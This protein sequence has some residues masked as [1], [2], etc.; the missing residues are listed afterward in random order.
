MQTTG[1]FQFENSNLGKFAVKV[2]GQDCRGYTMADMARRDRLQSK[3]TDDDYH[4][5]NAEYNARVQW[6]LKQGPAFW[7]ASD[8]KH[9]APGDD[10]KFVFGIPPWHPDGTPNPLGIPDNRVVEAVPKGFELPVDYDSKIGWNCTKCYEWIPRL[11]REYVGGPEPDDWW[12]CLSCRKNRPKM[13]AQAKKIEAIN[14]QIKDI[15][16]LLE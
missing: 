6:C 12:W 7:P 14:R 3:L 4:R 5:H 8:N 16:S 9:R 10:T 11:P 13:T 1:S 2:H 15:R